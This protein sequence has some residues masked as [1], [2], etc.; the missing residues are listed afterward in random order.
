[1]FWSQRSFS[2]GRTLFNISGSQ[3]IF[4]M[5]VFNVRWF[6]S[7]IQC[8]QCPLS[9]AGSSSARWPLTIGSF[10]AWTSSPF[11]SSVSYLCSVLPAEA[12]E[13]H[14]M[15]DLR[16]CHVEQKNCLADKLEFLIH[17]IVSYKKKKKKSGCFQPWNFRVIS[18]G[19]I[20]NWN[21]YHLSAD[22]SQ[23][24]RTSSLN[25]RFISDCMFDISTG[26]SYF[27]FYQNG[28]ET[29][30]QLEVAYLRGKLRKHQ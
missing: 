11:I 29:R 6:I 14:G 2:V 18:L 21:N 16:W 27:E 1:M 28:P 25:S 9:A 12:A 20:D 22:D 7:S 17:K 4:T 5:S 10:R 26:T 8:R 19:A 24:E 23:I 13:Y 3:Q 30:I 15:T